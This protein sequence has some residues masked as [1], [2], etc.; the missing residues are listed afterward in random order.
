MIYSICIVFVY[1][2]NRVHVIIATVC[3]IYT[4]MAISS[5]GVPVSL[6]AACVDIFSFLF[7]KKSLGS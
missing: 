1:T 6:L 7:V 3:C 5:N 2:S 4:I